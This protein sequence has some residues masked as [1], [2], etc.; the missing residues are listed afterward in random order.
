MNNNCKFQ[1]LKLQ[2]DVIYSSNLIINEDDI[3]DFVSTLNIQKNINDKNYSINNLNTVKEIQLSSLKINDWGLSILI[4]CILRSRRLTT[5]NLSN[6]SLTNDSANILSKCLKH[7]PNL[8]CLNLSNNLIKCEGAINII[9]EFFQDNIMENSNS[10][11]IYQ[12]DNVEK[13]KYILT[14]NNNIIQSKCHDIIQVNHKNDFIFENK[15]CNNILYYKQEKY[16]IPKQF[17]NYH[18]ICSDDK[19]Y[20]FIEDKKEYEDLQ[21]IDMSDNF[22]GI[23]FIIKLSDILYKKKDKTKYKIVIKNVGINKTSISYLLSKCKDVEILNI[24]EN[25]IISDNLPKYIEILFDVQ[26]NLK[27]LHLASICGDHPDGDNNIDMN[28]IDRN[29]INDNNNIDR[30][31]ID[32]NNIDMNNI[33]MNNIDRNNIDRNNINNNNHN[34]FYNDC[35]NHYHNICNNNCNNNFDNVYNIITS[36]NRIFTC[37]I[38]NLY[39]AKNLRILCLSNNNINDDNFKTF[40][41]HVQHNKDNKIEEIDFSYNCITDLSPLNECLKNNDTLKIINLSNNHITDDKIKRFC[42]EN[43]ATNLNIYELS[44]AYNKLTNNSCIYI[45]DA[46]ISQATLIKTSLKETNE[47]IKQNSSSTQE[48]LDIYINK[49]RDKKEIDNNKMNDNIYKNTNNINNIYNKLNEQTCIPMNNDKI[50][51]YTTNKKHLNIYNDNNNNN[52]NNNKED[53]SNINLLKDIIINRHNE[54][55]NFFSCIGL[56]NF[57]RATD[58]SKNLYLQEKRRNCIY[59]KNDEFNKF[60]NCNNIFSVNCLKGLK[61]LNLSGSNINNDGISYLLKSLKTSLCTLE[62]LDISC[63]Q[64]LTDNTYQAFTTLISYKKHKFLKTKNFI[65]KHLPLTVRGIPP[66]LI[67]LYDSEDNTDKNSTESDWWNYKKED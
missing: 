46:L 64:D 2:N 23:N 25:N 34:D 66:I 22:L 42:Y 48:D 33:D 12:V 31:N 39:K 17:N 11:N 61:F 30:N 9:E 55:N 3:A 29:N 6:N 4:P 59:K 43:L 44:L 62:Y 56:S 63:C 58:L 38:K 53:I 67:P 15:N 14:N 13:K 20:S 5:L 21:E 37:L 50:Q 18:H 26:P 8:R 19:Y 27:Q 36:Q 49:M 28:N 57:Y 24:S 41:L 32:R 16:I 40:C 45:S 52:N 60:Y 7:L 35:Y 65:F 1:K 10:S 47:F 51:T 54:E